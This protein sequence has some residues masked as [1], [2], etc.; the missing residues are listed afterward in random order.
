MLK[1]TYNRV[2]KPEGSY[3]GTAIRESDVVNLQR[4]GTGFAAH[5]GSAAEAKKF[6]QLGPGSGRADL[7]GQHKAARSLGGLVFNN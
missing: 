7:R 4:G 5:D 2:V 1:D 3:N 6:Y